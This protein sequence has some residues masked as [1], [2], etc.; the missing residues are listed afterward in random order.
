M[1]T[2]LEKNLDS[3]WRGKNSEIQNY[4]LTL[5]RLCHPSSFSVWSKTPNGEFNFKWSY[6]GRS[7]YK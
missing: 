7:K 5:T 6:T 1:V 2:S 4:K 3:G